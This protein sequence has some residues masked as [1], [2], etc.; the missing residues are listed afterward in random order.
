VSSRSWS[1][2]SP[3]VGRARELAAVED[4]FEL[5]VGTRSCRLVTVIGAPGVGKSRLAA[6]VVSRL[7]RQATVLV[8]RC[9]PYGEGITYWPVV[10]AVKQV[11]AIDD[12]DSPETVRAKI[13]GCLGGDADAALVSEHVAQVIGFGE[14]SATSEETF[15]AVRRLL[16]ALAER[17]PLVLLVEDLHW[18]SPTLLDLVEYVANWWSDAPL[19]VLCLARPELLELRPAWAHVPYSTS[20]QLE[21]LSAAETDALID[22][23]LRGL[24]LDDLG[25][26]RIKDAAEGNPLFVEQ[27]LAMSAETG[28]LAVP[29]TI[30][31]LLAARLDRL[32][33]EEREVLECASVVGRS[34]S[35]EAVRE[36]SPPELRPH[37]SEQ[38]M[39]LVRKELIAPELGTAIGEHG[40]RFRHILIRD[41]TYGALLKE[42]RGDLHERLAVWMDAQPGEYDEIVGY[43]YEQA[44]QYRNE[45]GPADE[46]ARRLAL[47]AGDRLAAAGRRA[48]ARGDMPATANLLERASLLLPQDEDDRL[49]LLP[50]LGRAL[51][52]IGALDH[53]DAVLTE[54]MSLADQA[55]DERVRASARLNRATLALYANPDAERGV[56]DLA[57]AAEEAAQ[58][59]AVHEDHA[60]LA[61]AWA[62]LAKV[63]WTTCRYAAMEEVLDRAL[64][65]ATLAGDRY[66]Q[67][68]IRSFLAR[69]ALLGP[70]PV[71]PAITRCGIILAEASGNPFHEAVA[72]VMIGGLEAMR[73]RFD[74]ARVHFERSRAGFRDLG[75]TRWLAALAV[76]SGPAE[77]LAGAADRAEG[78]LR[79]SYEALRA[80]GDRGLLSPVAAFLAQ[81]L[82]DQGSYGDAD[83]FAAVSEECA[84]RD[85]LFPHVVWRG[86]RARVLA[87]DGERERAATLAREAVE[88][89]RR[90]DSPNLQGDACLNLAEAL[91]L[92]GDDAESVEWVEQAL[93][94]YEAKGNLASARVAH[95]LLAGASA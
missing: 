59:F 79:E 10:E 55:G 82:Y 45:L 4:A 24:E 14:T 70:M 22:A 23:R 34:F 41:A 8:G 46:R 33:G 87:R 81:A 62:E 21:P 90:T 64:S 13:A 91:R 42:A 57:A 61:H 7:E 69:A 49:A 86:V 48:L 53:A 80:M 31:A 60:G 67:A 89:A 78:Q 43:H 51:T 85:D 15:W 65:E 56:Q 40:F 83:G 88:L 58:V 25:R 17:A 71:E 36:L 26:M 74:Q 95:G 77:L 68:L 63:H 29:P 3:L 47:D 73:G 6:E 84:S 93:A 54:A 39:G 92:V 18:A 94:L 1:A 16:A 76:W 12:G 35:W 66:E 75:H 37:L 20:V 50:E 30:H 44:F 28:D 38:L 9:L 11:A 72:G 27:M 19:L 5:A 52:E 2:G 32:E